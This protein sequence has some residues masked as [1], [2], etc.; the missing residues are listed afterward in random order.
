MD[1]SIYWCIHHIVISNLISFNNYKRYRKIV[2]TR[3]G[4]KQKYDM[5][6]GVVHKRE[7]RASYEQKTST[8]D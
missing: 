5:I 8:F 7:K 4:E 1:I 6:T 2:E 3:F